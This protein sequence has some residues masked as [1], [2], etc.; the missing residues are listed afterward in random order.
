MAFFPA[1]RLYFAYGSSLSVSEMKSRCPTSVFYSIAVLRNHRWFVNERGYANIVPALPGPTGNEDVVWGILYTLGAFDEELLDKHEGIPW[2]YSK[3][4]MDVEAVSITEDGRATRR[5][6]VRAMVYIDRER[7]QESYAWP[8]FIVKMNK[9]IQEAVERGVPSTWIQRVVRSY[10]ADPSTVNGTEG[11]VEASAVLPVQEG[12][13]PTSVTRPD[14]DG[15][16]HAQENLVGGSVVNGGLQKGRP[17][18]NSASHGLEKSK[19]AHGGEMSGGQERK[20][21]KDREM[22]IVHKKGPALG[23]YG[24]ATKHL[25]CWWWKV[26]GCCH[27]S[28]EECAYAHYETGTVANAPGTKKKGPL[29]EKRTAF[30]QPKTVSRRENSPSSKAEARKEHDELPYGYHQD[31]SGEQS[32]AEANPTWGEP[33]GEPVNE[34]VKNLMDSDP[35][36]LTANDRKDIKW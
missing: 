13:R 8:E 5:E 2:A 18:H 1:Q 34:P 20:A 32:K 3:A 17:N 15:A 26:K 11:Q 16:S 21:V 30:F 7:V 36:W 33:V 25:E 10:I 14:F 9:G 23:A 19:Y 12:T 31:W 4:D 24:H 28:D 27:F 6:V 29:P 22:V 35:E